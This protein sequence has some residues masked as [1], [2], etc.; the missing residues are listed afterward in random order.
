MRSLLATLALLAFTFAFY[1]LLALPLAFEYSFAGIVAAGLLAGGLLFSLPRGRRA[2][3]VALVLAFIYTLAAARRPEL[4]GPGLRALS[5]A[6]L[7]LA[8]PVLAWLA[9]RAPWRKTAL[10]VAIAAAVAATFNTDLAP[11]LTGFYPKWV[12]P[13]LADEPRIPFLTHTLADL[14]GDGTPEIIA[15]GL[16]A[17]RPGSKKEP[18]SERRF[19]Y[20]AFR[21]DGQGFGPA[22][23]DVEGRQ[24]LAAT[25]GNDYVAT[26][27]LALAWDRAAG[28]GPT[29]GFNLPADPFAL[30]GAA[31]APGHLPASLLALTLRDVADSLTEREAVAPRDAGPTPQVPAPVRVPGRRDLA[32]V[33][34]AA[35]LNGDGRP[36]RLIN[37]PDGGAAILAADGRPLWQA[38]NSSFRFESVGSLGRSREPQI[39]AMNKGVT[40]LDPRRYLGGY[41]LA[42]NG[43]LVRDWKVFMPGAVNPVPGDVDGDGRNELV[44]NLYGTHRLV[45]LE[46]HGL[47]VS[48][49]MYALTFLL[50]GWNLRRRG[51]NILAPA[52]AGAFLALVLTNSPVVTPARTLASGAAP[53]QPD[54]GATPFPEGARLLAEAVR[55]SGDVTR[56]RYEGQTITYLGKRRNQVDYTGIVAP[57]EMKGLTSLWGETYDLYRRGNQVYIHDRRAGKWEGRTLTGFAPPGT[58]GETL[59][60]LAAL[61]QDVHIL[62]RSE[63]VVRTP[64]RVLVFYPRPDQVAALLPPDLAPQAGPIREA[65]A[66]GGFRVMV[67]VGEQDGR[68][69][70]VQFTASLPAPD[71]GVLLQKTLIKF[72]EFNEAAAAIERP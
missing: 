20:H 41:H 62:P 25:V 9:A 3:T 2:E 36:E 66:R 18:L 5:L 44:L 45:V 34:A 56:L 10:A 27:P 61:A 51:R 19:T 8:Y 67:W 42:G 52:A 29:F 48:G 72:W 32:L 54:A 16:D 53:P 12:S 50:I 23:L 71:T 6:V 26:P 30:A 38:P 31:A 64:S 68:I 24:R 1:H 4:E 46:R 37:Y 22:R 58:L 65:L 17:G 39:I 59:A 70:Q 28:A 47:P 15:A 63:I 21:W 13:R 43:R 49:A 55:R 35:D 69:R 33:A 14:D 60:A 40:G 57:D 7:L 11:A